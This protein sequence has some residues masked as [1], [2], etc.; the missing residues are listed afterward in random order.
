[1][2][3]ISGKYKGKQIIPPKGFRARPT[4]DFARESLFN[5]LST[6]YDFTGMHIL[7]LFAGT[8]SIGLEFASRGATAVT[9]VEV[10]Y[11]HY[12]FIRK[13]L[14]GLDLP[15]TSVIHSNVK[16]FLRAGRTN[17]DIIFADPPYDLDWL[18]AIPELVIGAGIMNDDAIFILEHPKR[19]SFL[20]NPHFIEQ[21]HYGSVNFTFFNRS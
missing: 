11:K 8:G 9:M 2:R 4:T 21:R 17:Y 15:R 7:D 1:M 16:S 20:E 6:R 5:I 19:I 10:N 14:E 18:P 3:I 12:S 13:T